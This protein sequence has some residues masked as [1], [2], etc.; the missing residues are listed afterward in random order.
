[1]LDWH[2]TATPSR[3]PSLVGFD[4]KVCIQD[5]LALNKVPFLFGKIGIF[6]LNRV[7]ESPQNPTPSTQ[8]GGLKCTLSETRSP[9]AK[10][11]C[12]QGMYSKSVQVGV[13]SFN[14]YYFNVC[15]CVR[16]SNAR[17]S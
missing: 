4:F 2:Q 7:S 9:P 1:M 16:A 10:G 3:K 8:S 12:F 15:V 11:Q 14:Y 6:W 17:W 13:H 5:I